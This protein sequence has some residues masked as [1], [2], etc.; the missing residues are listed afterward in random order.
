MIPRYVIMVPFM[1]CCVKCRVDNLK[2]KVN[3]AVNS[4]TNKT[5]QRSVFGGL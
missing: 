1:K 5:I 4:I 3:G 2:L